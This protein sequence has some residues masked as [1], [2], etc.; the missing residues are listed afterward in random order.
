VDWWA[1]V[2]KGTGVMLYIGHAAYKVNNSSY[3]TGEP[4]WKDA[5]QLTNQVIY[6]R[7][8]NEYKGSVFFSYYGLT[9]LGDSVVKSSTTNL[10]NLYGGKLPS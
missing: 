7:T 9:N 4:N 5:M 3:I 1:N 2:C 6:A 8:K 10:V